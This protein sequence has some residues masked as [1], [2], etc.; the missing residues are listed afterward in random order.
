MEIRIGILQCDHVAE[1]LI[2][3]HGDYQDMFT[4]LI[5]SQG[6][7]IEI[8]VY[9]LTVGQFPVDLNTCDGYLITGSQFSA[10]E[11][12]PWIHKTKVLIKGLFQAQIPTIGICFG[13]QL[14][15]EALG[16]R[17]E[18]AADK[19][20]GVGV[21]E[22][23][24]KSQQVWMSKKPLESLS[25]LASHQDQVVRMPKDATLIA[26]SDFCPIAGFHANSIVTF[27]GHPE[28]SKEY[29]QALIENRLDR[30]DKKTANSAIT[31]LEKEVDSRTVA[32]WMVDFIKNSRA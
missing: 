5:Q 23:Q 16:G 18:R 22:W 32:S 21:H 25:M 6:N 1:D 30:I 19:G 20:W 14:I 12:I 2:E 11:D 13:H 31:S 29:L 9:D 17:V 15:A 27:Q 26:S 10:F 8:S 24:V 7:D 28:F 3:A 4:D